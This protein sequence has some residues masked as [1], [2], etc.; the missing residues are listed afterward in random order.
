MVAELHTRTVT[1]GWRRDLKEQL[2]LK[3]ATDPSLDPKKEGNLVTG[4]EGARLQIRRCQVQD[5]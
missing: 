4:E 2:H 1:Q 3:A 5:L